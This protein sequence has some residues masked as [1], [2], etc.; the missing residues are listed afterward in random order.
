LN[1]NPEF[2]TYISW[3][4]LGGWRIWKPSK[5]YDNYNFTFSQTIGIIWLFKF[6]YQPCTCRTGCIS[7]FLS[8][9]CE[10]SRRRLPVGL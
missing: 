8:L 5:T 7:E 2:F 3:P 1:P 4:I 10:I 9:D 6:R